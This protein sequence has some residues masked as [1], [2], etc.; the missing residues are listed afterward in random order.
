MRGD[1]YVIFSPYFL[2]NLGWVDLQVLMVGHVG[3]KVEI[4]NV[5]TKVA[6]AA[7]DA[8]NGDVDMQFDI[9]H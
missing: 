8:V 9:G 1:V 2:R 4:G 3:G 5:K 7:V 6:G